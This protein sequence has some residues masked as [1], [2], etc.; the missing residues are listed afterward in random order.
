MREI[1]Y[2]RPEGR[3]R[4]YV[5]EFVEVGFNGLPEFATRWTSPEGDY[6]FSLLVT[7]AGWHMHADPNF[8]DNPVINMLSRKNYTDCVWISPAAGEKLGLSNGDEVIVETNPKYMPELPRPVR[9]KVYLT[10]RISRDD[11]VLLFHGIGH[12]Y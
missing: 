4:M 11:C 9:S 10:T 12:R 6:Q 3:I 7:R 2:G 5:D 8:I 1:G